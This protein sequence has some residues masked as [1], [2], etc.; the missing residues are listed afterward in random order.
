VTRVRV[1]ATGVV[2]P[3]DVRA[4]L[5][6]ETVLISVM[7]ANNELGTIQPIVEIGRIAREAAVPLHVDGV[8]ALGKIRWTLPRWAPIY[9]A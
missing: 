7:H 1:G 9:T 3:D 8:Q 6:P 5:R 2:N 4:A